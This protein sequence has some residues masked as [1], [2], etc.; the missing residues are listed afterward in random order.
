ML[1]GTSYGEAKEKLVP[2]KRNKVTIIAIWR[3][4]GP[5]QGSPFLGREIMS[6][7]AY[8]FER[9]KAARK[10][11]IKS[12]NEKEGNPW[13]ADLELEIRN[14]FRLKWKKRRPENAPSDVS[15]KKKGESNRRKKTPTWGA[16]KKNLVRRGGIGNRDKIR[17]V[18]LGTGLAVFSTRPW[19]LGTASKRQRRVKEKTSR[20]RMNLV[21]GLGKW[22]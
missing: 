12:K 16:L 14:A 2:P 20:S 22:G 5:L 15:G 4:G 1:A 9:E 18:G 19:V 13:D 21:G 7:F 6:G 10:T 3:K 8:G 17:A 11:E